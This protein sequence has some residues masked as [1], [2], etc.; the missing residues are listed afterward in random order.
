MSGSSIAASIDLLE[1]GQHKRAL[2]E[3]AQSMNGAW[4]GICPA[5]PT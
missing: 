3:I 5:P 4:R 2:G 1:T